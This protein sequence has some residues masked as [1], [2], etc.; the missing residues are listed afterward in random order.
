LFDLDTKRREIQCDGICLFE[1]RI[2]CSAVPTAV[3][4]RVSIKSAS[5]PADE[6][7]ET[8]KNLLDRSANA[9]LAAPARSEITLEHNVRPRGLVHGHTL[10]N[11]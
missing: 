3:D 7:L 11:H 8:K 6:S 5:V 4:L 1:T 2:R 9:V 10:L